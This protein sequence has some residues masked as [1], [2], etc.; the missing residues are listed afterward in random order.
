MELM[1]EKKFTIEKKI[2]EENIL[3]EDPTELPQFRE[4]MEKLTEY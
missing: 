3:K 4:T 1:K 2:T